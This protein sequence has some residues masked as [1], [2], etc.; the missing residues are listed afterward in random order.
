MIVSALDV[1]KESRIRCGPESIYY[2][3]PL[4][5]CSDS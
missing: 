2:R 3:V 4:R 1:Y 5:I